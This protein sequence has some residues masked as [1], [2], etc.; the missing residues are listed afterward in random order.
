LLLDAGE[1]GAPVSKLRAAP[2]SSPVQGVRAFLMLFF[3]N[4]GSQIPVL[5]FLL[6]ELGRAEGAGA[7]SRS[8][9]RE[10]RPVGCAGDEPGEGAQGGR[11][12]GSSDP[13]RLPELTPCRLES[14]SGRDS[15][16]ERLGRQRGSSDPDLD[17]R[18]RNWK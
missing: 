3:L 1:E 8:G 11:P 2:A 14:E 13:P 6:P 17:R 7:R 15:G 10:A 16:L 4:G 9:V 12:E 18:S 5:K